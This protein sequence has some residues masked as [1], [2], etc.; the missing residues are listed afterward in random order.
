MSG[1][2]IRDEVEE[3]V[4]SVPVP[5]AAVRVGQ[6]RKD[7]EEARPLLDVD[8]GLDGIGEDLVGRFASIERSTELDDRRQVALL[9][10]RL[11]LVEQ[12]IDLGIL[13]EVLE[14]ARVVPLLRVASPNEPSAVGTGEGPVEERVVVVLFVNVAAVEVGRNLTGHAKI[15]GPLERCASPA[16]RRSS[17][18]RE[19]ARVVRVTRAVRTVEVEVLRA[20]ERALGRKL[21]TR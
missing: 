12:S 8:Q 1:R 6:T 19:L 16:R 9:T 7:G 13:A 3:V 14:V 20:V 4:L 15:H 5:D 18:A 17:V 21:S 2:V 11:E 10:V